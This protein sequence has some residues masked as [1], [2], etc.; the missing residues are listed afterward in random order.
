M[1][2]QQI[3]ETVFFPPAGTQVK[4]IN[5]DNLVKEFTEFDDYQANLKAAE[6]W[7]ADNDYKPLPGSQYEK[8]LT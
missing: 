7:L 6:Q 2:N 4:D 3:V 8:L 5:N 1:N